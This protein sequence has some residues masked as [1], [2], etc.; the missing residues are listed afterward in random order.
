MATKRRVF[1]KKGVSK[2]R[3]IEELLDMI[4]QEKFVAQLEKVREFEFNAEQGDMHFINS[5]LEKDWRW[6]YRLYKNLGMDTTVRSMEYAEGLCRNVEYLVTK[7]KKSPDEAFGQVYETLMDICEG[8]YEQIDYI[9][10]LAIR[11]W[12]GGYAL[13][14]WYSVHWTLNI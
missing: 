9:T 3:V 11:N 1:L 5:S 6:I 12:A 14:M 8:D 4:Q 10:T 13:K 7:Q 2:S